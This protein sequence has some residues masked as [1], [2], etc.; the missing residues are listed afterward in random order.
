MSLSSS[1]AYAAF[2]QSADYLEV[3]E[4]D[5]W[6]FMGDPCPDGFGKFIGPIVLCY[7]DFSDDFQEV[8]VK[9]E[10][11]DQS[12]LFVDE[13]KLTRILEVLKAEGL[14]YRVLNPHEASLKIHK[15]FVKKE[16]VSYAVAG[17]T[18]CLCYA[19]IAICSIVNCP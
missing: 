12:P 14:G 1:D 4:S 2:H 8:L 11:I 17:V 9:L 7:S 3:Q 6:V 15:T 19:I 10:Q 5:F 16:P 18:T 13:E